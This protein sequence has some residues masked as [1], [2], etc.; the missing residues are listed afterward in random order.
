MR[1][2]TYHDAM[3]ADPHLESLDCVITVQTPGRASVFPHPGRD[4]GGALAALL[5]PEP[6]P[7]V[8]EQHVLP[9]PIGQRL[10][11][12]LDAAIARLTERPEGE[13]LVLSEGAEDDRA[14]PTSEESTIKT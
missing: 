1:A 3:R 10:V 5:A 6:P 9:P 4:G 2:T 12:E 8:L 14:A 13:R 11:V 7:D